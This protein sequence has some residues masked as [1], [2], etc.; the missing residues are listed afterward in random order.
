M[1]T[2][3][4]VNDLLTRPTEKMPPNAGEVFGSGDNGMTRFT[5]TAASAAALFASSL[6][7]GLITSAADAAPISFVGDIS[8]NSPQVMTYTGSLDYAATDDTT[9]TLTLVLESSFADPDGTQAYLTA[10]ALNDPIGFSGVSLTTAPNTNFT[11]LPSGT[12]SQDT[13][14]ADP[15]GDFDFGATAT[16][17]T[18]QGGGNPNG[19]VLITPAAEPVTSTFAWTLTA[20]SGMSALTSAD[21]VAALSSSPSQGYG[22]Q[23]LAV[24]YRGIDCSGDGC[25]ADSDKVAASV[26]PIPAAL[27]LLATA[28]AALGVAAW[29]RDPAR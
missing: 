21:F 6:T 26:V 7:L 28:L 27:P 20:A 4:V 23:F 22:G 8:S 15:F 10:A 3:R 5:R 9:G 14:A 12:Y 19:G 25:S 18:W 11:V 24:R 13:V 16:G 29:R 2:R 17:S 1:R